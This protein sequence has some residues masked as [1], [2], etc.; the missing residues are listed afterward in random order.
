LTERFPEELLVDA[1]TNGAVYG[2]D[3]SNFAAQTLLNWKGRTKKAATPL[4]FPSSFGLLEV[5][6]GT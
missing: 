2:L 1:G 6:E 4:T 5:G 3:L